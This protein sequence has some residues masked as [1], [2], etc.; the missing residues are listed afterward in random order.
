MS[1]PETPDRGY[2]GDRNSLVSDADVL[3]CSTFEEW[4]DNLG[5]DKDSRK[6]EATYR[7]CLALALKLR[8]GLGE[9]ALAE[10]REAAQ[11]Y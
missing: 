9:A 1:S 2:M 7:E 11:D 8:N 4:A 6:A 10:L 5:Y 3:D